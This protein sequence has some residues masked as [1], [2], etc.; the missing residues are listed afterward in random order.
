MSDIL[1]I[2][3]IERKPGSGVPRIVGTR[4]TVPIIVATLQN[5]PDMTVQMM[6]E[7]FELTEG[8]IYAALSYYADHSE[9]IER[10]WAEGDALAE[11]IGTS[12]DEI[13]AHIEER[14]QAK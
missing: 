11:K 8:Q 4:F 2:N 12:S 6:A 13:R 9:E 7:E 1:S 3:H 14:R 10:L 5:N